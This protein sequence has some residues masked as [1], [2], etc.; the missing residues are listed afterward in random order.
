MDSI[1]MIINKKQNMKSGESNILLSK[2]SGLKLRTVSGF[3]SKGLILSVSFIFVIERFFI[4][5][6]GR[7]IW[8]LNPALLSPDDPI[9]RSVPNVSHGIGFWVLL[10]IPLKEGRSL[11]TSFGYNSLSPIV[12]SIISLTLE[13][14][15]S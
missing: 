13:E 2:V 4:R 14:Q 1:S 3:C 12:F 11:I 5:S 8:S 10:I 9:N 6:S 15:L 7:N